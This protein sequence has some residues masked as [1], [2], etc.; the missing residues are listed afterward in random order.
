MLML[1]YSENY[2]TYLLVLKTTVITIY[3]L[4][5]YKL[6]KDYILSPKKKQI[7]INTDIKD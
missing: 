6:Y 3:I 2:N 7:N 5:M 4:T 1:L